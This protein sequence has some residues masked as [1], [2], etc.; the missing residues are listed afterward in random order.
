[1]KL[2]ILRS[3]LLASSNVDLAELIRV[4][5]KL[6][7]GLDTLGTSSK[8]KAIEFKWSRHRRLLISAQVGKVERELAFF[9]KEVW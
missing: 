3:L 5:M 7:H 8:V 2:E 6:K 1:L 4:V 9:V